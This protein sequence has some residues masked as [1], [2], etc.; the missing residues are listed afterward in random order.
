[1]KRKLFSAV[2]LAA[3]M[4]LAGPSYAAFVGSTSLSL[5]YTCASQPT[6]TS[7]SGGSSGTSSGTG[8]GTGTSSSGTNGLPSGFYVRV[9]MNPST[10]SSASSSGTGGYVATYT[11]PNNP[12]VTVYTDPVNGDCTWQGQATGLATS[13]SAYN[14][15]SVQATAAPGTTSVPA[16]TMVSFDSSSSSYVSGPYGTETIVALFTDNPLFQVVGCEDSANASVACSTPYTT[17]FNL[18]ANNNNSQGQVS[19]FLV[20]YSPTSSETQGTVD[21]ANIIVEV[22]NSTGLGYYFIPMSGLVQ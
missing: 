15:G 20:T 21:S 12:S 22:S 2:A 19:Q 11:D 10:W 4:L 5:V 6:G 17:S 18:G 7:G 1:M 8:A 13:I 14:G 9:P 16:S 3:S